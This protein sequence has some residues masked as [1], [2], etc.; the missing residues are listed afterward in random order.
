[1]PHVD[2]TA[3][4]PLIVLVPVVL[5]AG[6]WLADA[7]HRRRGA[8]VLALLWNLIG[9]T[10]LNILAVKTGWWA[11]ANGGPALMR[12]P[13]DLLVAWAV[14][15]SMIP[16][17]ASRWIPLRYSAVGL[18]LVDLY[19]MAALHPVVV[20]RDDWWWGETAAV[21][22]CLVPGLV[23]AGL[24]LSR[25]RLRLRVALQVVL[26]TAVLFAAIPVL[27]GAAAEHGPST[28]WLAGGDHRVGGALDVIAIQL[29]LV[30]GLVAL[31][32]VV[33]FV[34]AGGTPWPWD[35]PD[36]LVTTGPY[37]YVANPMQLC[38]TVL[39]LITAVVLSMPIL[40]VAAVVAAA[41]SS[42]MAA[43]VE[44]E[45]LAGRF[46]RAWSAY[47][48]SVRDWLPHWRPMPTIP[49]A[50]VYLARGCDPC[51]ELAGWIV[52]HE[53]VGLTICD[54]EDYP[55]HLRRMRYVSGRGDRRDGLRALAATLAHVNLAW[56]VVGWVIGAP[57]IAPI[58]Q[59]LVDACGGGPRAIGTR[60][61]TGAPTQS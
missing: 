30:V 6:L 27:G 54:A 38:G 56:A 5:A 28:A 35:P 43:W 18:V 25:T 60:G 11:F 31:A 16:V 36:S 33:E 46:G 22:T 44:D 57:V 17:L 45:A 42:G 4:R 49:P 14:A 8:A 12:I 23:L 34:R 61:S 59:L 55:G 48:S 24:T 26:F 13:L 50:R 1:M 7:D 20:L 15:W 39:I 40:V 52:A 21:L 29:A 53:P 47:R 51:S 37:A 3:L 58:L 9:L 19:G 10:A 41:F 32:A 2:V